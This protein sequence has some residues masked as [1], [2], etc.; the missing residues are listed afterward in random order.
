[1]RG[2]YSFVRTPLLIA[3]LAMAG[4]SNDDSTRPLVTLEDY[5]QAALEE[6]FAESDGNGFSVSV[7]IPGQPIWTG[8]AGVSHGSV[9]IT[10]RSVFAAGSTTKTFTGLTLLR[11]AE[12]GRLSLDDSLHA[13]FPEYP[14]VDP[15]ITLRQLLNHTS[16]MSDFV[17]PPT[18]FGDLFSE[19]GRVWG[20]E[21]YFLE[22]IRDPYFEKGTAWSY[23]TS[24]YLLLRML[25]EEVTGGTVA[26]AYREYV[27]D[28][29]GM[30]DTYTCPDEPLPGSLAHGWIDLTG[31]G[32][33]DDLTT[34]PIT[35]F[36]TS[37]GGQVYS[38][39]VDLAKLGVALMHDRT[40]LTDASYDEMK[41]FYFPY[42]H[43]E[44]LVYGYGLGLVWYNSAFMAGEKVWGHSGNAPGYAAGM[45]YLVDYGVVVSAMD[46]TEHGQAMPVL[47]RI[48]DVVTRY[49]DG[50]L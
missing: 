27:L 9:P 33:Y 46:N 25:I 18:W 50:E 12:E 17:D 26:A 47:E 34:V 5:L 16:G 30:S 45:F 35:A 2:A 29:V 48:F 7:L 38:T 31:D 24:G 15:D 13:W 11:L 41:D 42:A 10:S 1:M 22:T 37:T 6:G 40:I 3:A 14:H 36:C 44:P 19:P 23:S 49:M 28:P 43:D 20:M 32:V 8:V 4:C 21:E 39:S